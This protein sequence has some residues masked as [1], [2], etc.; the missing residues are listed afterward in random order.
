MTAGVAA[1][2]F[3]VLGPPGSGKGTQARRLG[4]RRGVPHISVGAV[5]R[6]EIERGSDLGDRIADQVEAGD[7]VDDQLIA[8]VLREPLE[9]APGWVL[10]GAPRTVEQA[11]LL[12]PLI[13]RPGDTGSPGAAAVVIVLEVSEDEIR[14]RLLRRAGRE[15]RAD[16]TSEVI[17]HRIETWRHEAPPL[18]EW[19][20]ERGMLVTV[21]GMGDVDDVAARLAAVTP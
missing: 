1:D 8:S 3:V 4:D 11:R 13:E 19:Y 15:A 9:N 12:A 5:L 21:D 20:A 7:L 17:E 18:L 6:A 14:A 16:D 2:R 10:D